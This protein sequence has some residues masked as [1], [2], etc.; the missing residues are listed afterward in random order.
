MKAFNLELIKQRRLELEMT[1]QEAAEAM[2]MKNASTYLKYENGTYSFRA[3]Q[4]PLLA[5]A[6][7]C[8]T[9][10]FFTA[11]IAKTAI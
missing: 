1:L 3:E 10:K 4:L 6:L 11:K 7:Q 9:E 2:E 8:S 5:K